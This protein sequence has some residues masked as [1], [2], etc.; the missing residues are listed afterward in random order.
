MVG[1]DDFEY[2]IDENVH[3]REWERS[4]RKYP[5]MFNP[6]FEKHMRKIKQR[7]DE[8]KKNKYLEQ[9]PIMVNYTIEELLS[10]EQLEIYKSE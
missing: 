9:K 1:G 10:A 8:R 4:R 5:N 3:R 7:R 2:S 6:N